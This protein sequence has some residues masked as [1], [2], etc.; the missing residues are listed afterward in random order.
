MTIEEIEGIVLT[1][2]IRNYG[3]TKKEKSDYQRREQRG[4]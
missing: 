3:N 1:I 2:K 4:R